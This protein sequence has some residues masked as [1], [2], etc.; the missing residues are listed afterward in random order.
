[1]IGFG[2]HIKITL[3]ILCIIGQ[4]QLELWVARVDYKEVKYMY[5]VN[6]ENI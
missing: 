4:H 6:M 5:S 2:N 3:Y 1:M